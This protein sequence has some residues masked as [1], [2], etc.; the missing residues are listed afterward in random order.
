MS[1]VLYSFNSI[2]LTDFVAKNYT[3][4]GPKVWT[5]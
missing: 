4:P 1:P 2:T 3:V 5:V